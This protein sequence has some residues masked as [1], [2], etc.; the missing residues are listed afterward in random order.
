MC[1]A[2]PLGKGGNPGHVP[3]VGLD[4]W[5]IFLSSENGAKQF[6]GNLVHIFNVQLENIYGGEYDMDNALKNRLEN[7]AQEMETY[8]TRH[9]PIVIH[10][11]HGRTRSVICV[12]VYLMYIHGVSAADALASM[13]AAFVAAE[14]PHYDSLGDRVDRALN[15]YEALNLRAPTQRTTRSTAKKI[16]TGNC[17]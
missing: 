7:F 5:T 14:A 9:L 11:N 17:G 2:T 16:C 13:Q 6:D 15:M 10:C 4:G 1:R 12:A 8:R 3:F